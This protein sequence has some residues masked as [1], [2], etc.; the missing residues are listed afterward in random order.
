[1]I[2]QKIIDKILSACNIVDVI[3][4]Y[5]TLTKKG[6]NHW[7]VC[8]FHTDRNP[9]M[10]VSPAKQIY[11]CFTCGE[12]GNAITFL[13]KHENMSY[14]EAIRYLGKKYNIDVPDKELSPEE[15]ERIKTREAALI[16]LKSAS[17][18]FRKNL[19]ENTE[20]KAYMEHRGWAAGIDTTL[21]LFQAGYAEN[22]WNSLLSS[23]Q[24]AAYSKE[25][26]LSSG[27][28]AQGERGLYDVFRNR[29]VFPY[30]D[31]RGNIIGFTGRTIA[32]DSK[33]S[34][35]LNTSDTDV[36]KKGNALFGLYQAKQAIGQ[37]DKV[38]FVEGQFDVLSFVRT[39]I[40]NTIC[41]SGTA[42][43]PEQI[44][45][46]TR[47]T[48]NI[49]LIYDKDEAGQK[50][51]IKNIK[52]LL[53]V[54]AH[55][56]AITLPEGE[57]PDSFARSIDERELGIY[58]HNHEVDWVTYL[59]EIHSPFFDDPIKKNEALNFIAECIALIKEKSLKTT[60]TTKLSE[61]FD[62]EINTV[63]SKIKSFSSTLPASSENMK[64]G[65]YGIEELK[66]TLP[67]TSENCLIT[68]NFH[69]FKELYGDSPVVYF[70]GIPSP[71]QIQELR[72][73]VAYLQYTGTTSLTFDERIESEQL[74]T[75]GNL[76]K[77][78]LT[79][80]IDNYEKNLE[81]VEY[82]IRAY[83]SAMEDKTG[84]IRTI[85]YGRCADIISS[86][87]EA[88][89]SVMEKEWYTILKLNAK[90]YRELLKPYLTKKKS[91]HAMLQQRSFD[92]SLIFDDPD[93]V[94]DYVEENEEYRINYKRHG[95]YPL[96]N[97]ENEPVSYMFKNPNG[98]GHTQVSDFYMIPLL[99]IYD[100]DSEYNKRVIKINRRYYKQPIYLEIKSK[101]L[102]SM[103]SFEEILLNEEALNF[104]N[105][106]VKHFKK[107]RQ[108]MS[109][110]YIKCEELKTYGQQPE[111]FYAFSNAIFHEVDGNYRVDMT[112]DLGVAT[113]N[114][115]NYYA[116]A[117]SQIYAG[118]RKDNDKYEQ[119]RYFIY[120]DIPEGKRC[121]FERWAYLMDKVYQINDNGKW[122]LIYAIMCAF[123]SDIHAIDRLFTALFI[124][125]PT[126]SGKTQVAISIRSLYISPDMPAFNLNSGTDAAFFSLM[127]GFRD[128]PQVLEEYN[129]KDITD[130]KFQGLKSITY[131]GDGKQKRKGTGSKDIETSK[132][133]SP[134]IILGQETPQRDDNALMNRVVVC[135]VPKKDGFSDEEK[136]IFQELKDYEKNG[137]CNILFEV[138]KLRPLVRMHYKDLQRQINKDLTASVLGAS[139]KSG[140][141]VRII[142]TVSLFLAMCKLMEEHAPHLKLP[143]TYNEFYKIA[144]KKV[145]TQVEMISRT[146]K[147][148]GFF[149]A[150]EVMINTKTILDGRDYA[151]DQ[152]G[153]LTLKM[154]GNERREIT[155]TP[156]HAKVLYL[157]LSTIHT[158]YAKSSYN[159]EDSSLSTIEANIR[160]NPAYIGV[161]NARR[162]KWKEV[163]EVPKGDLKEGEIN[164]EM[165]RIMEDKNTTTSCIAMNYDL[166]RQYFDID[167]E[168]NQ[169][170]ESSQEPTPVLPQKQVMTATDIPF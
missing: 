74:A 23:M 1:M 170:E 49:T 135:E 70:L 149:K 87:S 100:T 36:F 131:D 129:N 34:K 80:Y 138:L 37:Q 41:G 143:F 62:I 21:D 161:V 168:R 52:Q 44:K 25:V 56:R 27:L 83:A 65:F 26:L 140:D 47:F 75:L 3:G 86:A 119:L 89:Q 164:N 76:F 32:N 9:S 127:E 153:K 159:N 156:T 58:L 151:I 163:K 110:K 78:G 134:V 144:T 125:G 48:S 81:F 38:Y 139:N 152:P 90:S 71:D 99:H 148:A 28:I 22:S 92:D 111:N 102:A 112:S 109:Y 154:P 5:V 158:L 39:G 132:V 59:H 147:L 17:E 133:Y 116:P 72:R 20:A 67:D 114:G 160:S 60:Y 30:F 7:G 33:S 117:Y 157:R 4:E 108:A 43:T 19:L 121:T 118:L 77:S 146:D 45:T 2:E 145:I 123:R 137:L 124:M 126:M 103:Q 113:H 104:E 11:K 85:Y 68:D 96:L 8:P 162:F 97:K 54:G 142:N 115:I 53:T 120:K 141:M 24:Q 15:Q 84:D 16:A 18:K 57:D 105:G 150:V 128:V 64:P 40:R 69:T 91:K 14:P 73:H 55:V 93:V 169:N 61:L 122:A 13:Q 82:Y 12:A 165:I 63:K 31:L 88:A 6:V 79:I 95:F 101:S 136:V 51:S 46:I 35:Y 107:I 167:L 106:E 166:F 10:C 98:G 66:K 42:L 29:I 130:Q 50:A 155:M 94:P